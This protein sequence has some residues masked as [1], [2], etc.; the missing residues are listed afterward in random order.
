DVRQ[1]HAVGLRVPRIVAAVLILL[2]RIVLLLLIRRHWAGR[3]LLA[4]VVGDVLLPIQP[5]AA[6]RVADAAV[7]DAV[8]GVDAVDAEPHRVRVR[9]RLRTSVEYAA[10]DRHL[11]RGHGG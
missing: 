4:V 2:E 11:L 7:A 3:L 1:P 5:E 8:A 6:R 10:V 9:H